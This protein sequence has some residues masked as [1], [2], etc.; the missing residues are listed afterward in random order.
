MP[1][2]GAGKLANS[3]AGDLAFLRQTQNW[4]RSKSHLLA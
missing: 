4:K 1:R 3:P 2:Q